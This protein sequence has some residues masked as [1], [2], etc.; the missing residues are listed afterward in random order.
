HGAVGYAALAAKDVAQALN[1]LGLYARLRVGALDLR[2]LQTQDNICRIVLREQFD[3]ADTR[4]FICEAALVIIVRLLETILGQRLPQL[5]Y[6]LPYPAPA[7]QAEYANHLDGTCS[8]DAA[9]LEIRLPANLLH[10]PCLTADPQ[11]LASAR[12]D[13]EQALAQLQGD[14]DILQQVRLRLS[15]CD[16]N[17]PSSSALAQELNMSLRTMVRKLAQ[18]SSN[19]QT[20]LD[21]A[22]KEMAQWYLQNTGYTVEN[23]AE[24]LGYQDTSNF[25]RCC[26]RWFGLT[27]GQVRQQKLEK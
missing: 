22:R 1:L 13:C 3:L 14:A 19:Y 17:Y 24:R 26:K 11:A 4:I 12:K 27:A 7:W 5:A 8:F 25:S 6:R 20:L 15:A 9:C 18:H 16:G 10:A 21:E 2:V 23:I